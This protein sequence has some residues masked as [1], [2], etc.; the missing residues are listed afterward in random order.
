MITHIQ[1]AT[2]YVSDQDK[3]LDFYTSILGMSKRVDMPLGPGYRWVEVS[4]DGAQT[5]ISLARPADPAQTPGGFTGFILNTD[6]VHAFYQTMK[7][8]GVVFSQEPTAQPWGGIQASFSDP[9]G[10]QF[11]IAQRTS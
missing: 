3:A 5:S 9:D 2:V 10:N 8:R 1:V 7:S 4:P 11:L 6:D